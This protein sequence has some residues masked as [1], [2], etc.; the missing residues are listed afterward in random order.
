MRPESKLQIQ[1]PI[2]VCMFHDDILGLLVSILQ[3][4]LGTA[5]LGRLDLAM[6]AVVLDVLHFSTE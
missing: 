5:L 1:V 6:L 3:S 2:S 4:A